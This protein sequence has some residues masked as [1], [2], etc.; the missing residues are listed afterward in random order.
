MDIT[1]VRQFVDSP[2]LARKIYSQSAD[3]LWEMSSLIEKRSGEIIKELDNLV[4]GSYIEMKTQDNFKPTK[5]MTSLNEEFIQLNIAR[6]MMLSQVRFLNRD[7]EK[8]VVAGTIDQHKRNENIEG[9]VEILID[10]LS[11]QQRQQIMNEFQKNGQEEYSYLDI[12]DMSDHLFGPAMVNRAI[13]IEKDQIYFRGLELPDNVYDF[14]GNVENGTLSEFYDGI[15]EYISN[16]VNILEKQGL[17]YN[18]Q[19][20]Q[21]LKKVLDILYTE[22]S[23]TGNYLS[24]SMIYKS[25]QENI[26]SLIRK[27]DYTISRLYTL[28]DHF[29]I[30]GPEKDVKRLTKIINEQ[31]RREKLTY[32]Y[33]KYY[34]D[35]KI[36]K[37][38][39][40][41]RTLARTKFRL[42]KPPKILT[43]IW[44]RGKR[45]YDKYFD[46]SPTK[47]EKGMF[48]KLRNLL[49]KFSVQEEPT[50]NISG[51]AHLVEL[52]GLAVSNS[53]IKEYLKSEEF[54][55][56]LYQIL[57]TINAPEKT[58]Q[59]DKESIVVEQEL[60]P[61]TK[62]TEK[63]LETTVRI[64]KDTLYTEMGKNCRDLTQYSI[65]LH[66][67]P[68]K[69]EVDYE[70]DEI[71][72]HG[73]QGEVL[74]FNHETSEIIENTFP[75]E[76]DR[77]EIDYEELVGSIT[78]KQI[79]GEM[80]NNE[81]RRTTGQK[82]IESLK[83]NSI[84][85]ENG[86]KTIE[87]LYAASLN[88][89]KSILD[90]EKKIL[91]AI[92]QTETGYL[93]Y[94]VSL[95]NGN[96]IKR[97]EFDK[98]KGMIESSVESLKSQTIVS[99]IREQIMNHE[100]TLDEMIKE[101]DMQEKMEVEPT[102]YQTAE[103]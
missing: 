56:E 18:S 63:T 62:E 34:A 14:I 44:T 29:G 48:G 94:S 68:A 55:R 26:D 66:A 102:E 38:K 13:E 65:M 78:D 51:K 47:K 19:E 73:Y 49:Q 22:D 4:G 25:N 54:K 45:E 75:K 61:Q 74:R 81:F 57:K 21:E 40:I 43:S 67:D 37:E 86:R 46:L 28:R 52:R 12:L 98:D 87:G 32:K 53:D 50:K 88:C 36:A 92:K 100:L 82:I 96:D 101:N 2:I 27:A 6:N 77:L 17:E 89:D 91:Q 95:E 80:K 9:V 69:T 58:E 10:E 15:Q 72:L 83:K 84:Y 42:V 20:A 90:T 41:K 16:Q 93:V 31:R 79:K 1:D 103:R 7:V 24:K 64:V 23:I 99:G 59:K 11:N 85:S 71:V 60:K 5:E 33:N 35:Q 30:V 76:I 70:K 97:I 39:K 3:E 8:D